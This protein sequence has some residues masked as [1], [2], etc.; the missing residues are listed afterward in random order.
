MTHIRNTK[1]KRSTHIEHS[2]I[3]SL[4]FV[5]KNNKHKIISIFIVVLLCALFLVIFTYQPA[6]NL[7]INVC[8]HDKLIAQYEAIQ[9]INS[10]LSSEIAYLQTED[11]IYQRAT[12]KLGLVKK[13][14]HS[15]NVPELNEQKEG[16]KSIGSTSSKLAYKQIKTPER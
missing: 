16:D 6:K 13:G 12:E 7:Y 9:K 15:G 11:G 1:H 5:N 2:F 8:E 14:D 10:E 3:K 4:L